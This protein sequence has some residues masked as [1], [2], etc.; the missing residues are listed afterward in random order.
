MNT[1]SVITEINRILRDNGFQGFHLA[2]NPSL[3]D[4]YRVVRTDGATAV[5]LSEGERNFIAFV[6]FYYLVHGSHCIDEGHQQKIVVIDDPV[7]S[8][9]SATLHVVAFL[10]RELASIFENNCDYR[11]HPHLGDFIKQLFVLTQNSYF[12]REVSY[13]HVRDYHYASFYLIRKDNNVSN[14]THCTRPQPAAPSQRE[15]YTPVMNGYAALWHEYQEATSSVVLMNVMRRILEHYFLQLCGYDG[16]DIATRILKDN[17][18]RF[19]TKR[20][21]GHE[22]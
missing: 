12:F 13:N 1:Q 15:N 8:M 16:I 7:S 14:I 2:S 17:R 6:Y 9:D 11:H 3:P 5:G 18:E 21:D 20:E 4:T 10:V 22:D 19:I